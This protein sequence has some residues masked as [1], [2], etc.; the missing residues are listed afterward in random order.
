MHG[1]PDW[2]CAVRHCC[3]ATVVQLTNKQGVLALQCLPCTLF[4]FVVWQTIA[5]SDDDWLGVVQDP[6]LWYNKLKDNLPPGTE[7]PPGAVM[8]LHMA[9][10]SV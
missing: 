8:F 7:I 10:A 1:H 3:S 9:C 2:A 4:A 6:H 5:S